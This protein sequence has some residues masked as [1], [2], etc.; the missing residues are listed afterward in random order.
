MSLRLALTSLLAGCVLAAPSFAQDQPAAQSSTVIVTPTT[1][2][3][4]RVDES[5]LRYYA[6]N[7]Q[8]ERVEA[9]IRRLQTLHPGWTPPDDLFSV[10]P[11]GSGEQQFWDLF[12][13]DRLDE[14]EAAIA[15]PHR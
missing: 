8:M 5:A 13:A 11:A 6:R 15:R 4:E 3:P 10:N 1:A 2:Q 7:R 9:E 12:G 14:L